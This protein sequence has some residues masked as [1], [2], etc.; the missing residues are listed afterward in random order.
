VIGEVVAEEVVE[1]VRVDHH[2]VHAAEG[3]KEEE[4]Q[5][6]CVVCVAHTGVDPWT[7]VVHLRH[8]SGR[9]KSKSDN[10]VIWILDCLYSSIEKVCS[11]YIY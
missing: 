11:R 10:I 4:H 9:E 3:N 5:E 7:M 1:E 2:T 6:V 8:A